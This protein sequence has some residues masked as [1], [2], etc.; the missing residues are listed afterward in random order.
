MKDFIGRKEE[1]GG[2]L[3]IEKCLGLLWRVPNTMYT[4]VR[5]SAG[6]D[7]S[8]HGPDK[9]VSLEE[10]PVSRRLEMLG[11]VIGQTS[12]LKHPRSRSSV[13]R[14]RESTARRV[15]PSRYEFSQESE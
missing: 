1:K 2:E 4:S 10:F 3:K 11:Q 8:R 15:R 13:Y 14:F 7:T 9:R 5:E 12:I 6:L